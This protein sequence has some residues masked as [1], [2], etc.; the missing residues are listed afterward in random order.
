LQKQ[1][2]SPLTSNTMKDKQPAITESKINEFAF[3]CWTMAANAFRMYPNQKHA[4]AD[5]KDF[6]MEKARQVFGYETKDNS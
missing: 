5:V 4:Y 2:Q 6:L 3:E 1:N